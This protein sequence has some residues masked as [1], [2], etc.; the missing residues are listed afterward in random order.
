[1]TIFA[2][3]WV[4]VHPNIPAI[5]DTDV[6]IALRRTG[7]MVCGF[8]APEIIILWAMKQWYGARK[9]GQH[10]KSMWLFVEVSDNISYLLS[11]EQGWTTTHGFFLQMGGFMLYTEGEAQGPLTLEDLETLYRNGK[12]QWPKIT[13]AEIQDKSKG[14]ALSKGI[15]TLQ[16]SWFLVQCIVRGSTGLVITELE[17]LTLAFA[18]LNA[19]TYF[20]WWNK[21]M[22]VRYPHPVH[23]GSITRDLGSVDIGI[24]AHHTLS[25]PVHYVS[26][27]RSSGKG[28]FA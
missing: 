8:I 15:A 16:T 25:D 4:A 12:I 2:C 10:Y 9:I 27:L 24:Q 21:P 17:L 20:F 28:P 1:M 11:P 19:V 14:D 3:T 18:S 22:D 7:L 26:D 5:S 13:E 6:V 23:S